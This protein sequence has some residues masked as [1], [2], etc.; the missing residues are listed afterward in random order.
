VRDL[1]AKKKVAKK[2]K[3]AV[4][5]RWFAPAKKAKRGPRRGSDAGPRREKRPA[6]LDERA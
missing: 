1:P 4:K 2:A 3:P 5:R 6:D